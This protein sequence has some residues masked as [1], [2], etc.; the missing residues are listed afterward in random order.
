M[1]ALVLE[2]LEDLHDLEAGPA[3]EV[4]G[5]LVGE[6]DRRLVEERAGDRDALL[7]AARQLIRM[8]LGP[9]GKAD[10]VERRERAP[11]AL[12]GRDALRA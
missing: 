3:V 4:A 8:V 6:Q 2:A 11:P 5:R 10:G 1:P 12:G 7:L 9:I